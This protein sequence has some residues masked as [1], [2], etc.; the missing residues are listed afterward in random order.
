LATPLQ[1]G[2]ATLIAEISTAGTR[3]SRLASN[4]PESKH[5]TNLRPRHGVFPFPRLIFHTAS[6][7]VFH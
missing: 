2:P 3:G 6:D 5:A 7:L 4:S 1:R